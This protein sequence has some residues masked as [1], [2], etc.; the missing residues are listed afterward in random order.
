MT[1]SK[2]PYNGSEYS[3]TLLACLL[4]AG[5]LNN[6]PGFL[7]SLATPVMIAPGLIV[8]KLQNTVRRDFIG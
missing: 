3:S 2:P 5:H 6:S 4:E 7:F 8:S 1:F